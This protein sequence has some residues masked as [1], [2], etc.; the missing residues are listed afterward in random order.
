VY[1]LTQRTSKVSISLW[2]KPCVELSRRR[3]GISRGWN[4]LNQK[5]GFVDMAELLRDNFEVQRHVTSQEQSFT[6]ATYDTGTATH[7]CIA[8]GTT[9]SQLYSGASANGALSV[10]LDPENIQGL[11]LTVER[12]LRQTQQEANRDQQRLELPQPETI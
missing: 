9:Q 1:S 3:I 5:L 2:R 11:N 10:L 12:T 8:L 6:P 7:V 4:F